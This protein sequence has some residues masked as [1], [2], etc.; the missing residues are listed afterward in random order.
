MLNP[1]VALLT[2]I[3][4]TFFYHSSRDQRR[5]IR[6]A[7]WKST[8]L[9]FVLS[10][11]VLVLF[12]KTYKV[13]SIVNY[14]EVKAF[15]QAV[16]TDDGECYLSSW[17][18]TRAE[19][20]DSLD[21]D[22][23]NVCS[24]TNYLIMSAKEKQHYSR[25]G[26]SFDFPSDSMPYKPGRLLEEH[27]LKERFARV[28][29]RKYA[30]TFAYKT[31][32]TFAIFNQHTQ[33]PDQVADTLAIGIGKF[34]VSDLKNPLIQGWL[35]DTIFKQM[36]RYGQWVET[37]FEYY[38][39]MGDT[40]GT[41]LRSSSVNRLHALTLADISQCLYTLK[42]KSD[43]PLKTLDISFDLPVEF[44]GL[45]A[46]S[47]V[48]AFDAQLADTE[49]LNKNGEATYQFLVKFPSL[50]NVQFIR[51]LVL[52]TI[53]TAL[54]S[55]LLSNLYYIFR[56]WMLYLRRKRQRAH[57]LIAFDCA[58]KRR[59]RSV[60]AFSLVYFCVLC[61]AYTFMIWRQ[62]HFCVPE[63]LPGFLVIVLT[64][65]ICAVPLV[66]PVVA[67]ISIYRRAS[68]RSKAA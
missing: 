21:I 38:P 47:V 25:I 50:A 11:L 59:F 33:K 17:K 44:T 4:I 49:T 31:Q 22:I 14:I 55:L 23:D 6:Q 7:G 19:V 65:M 18:H 46:G 37:L 63:G 54:L 8:L 58:E 40:I 51:S 32:P 48:N 30:I 15:E 57:T 13:P 29:S 64:V 66:A 1:F 28:D 2:F 10:L 36:G 9:Y 52:T 16:R 26:F 68:R 67:Y 56:W 5:K 53:L 12:L 45:P 3:S 34:F 39:E 41:T 27:W 43:C 60:C 35:N 42:V 24:G 20:V 61:F 62:V